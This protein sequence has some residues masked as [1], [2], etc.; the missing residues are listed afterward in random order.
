MKK[1]STRCPEINT[2]HIKRKNISNQRGGR[3]LSN[4]RARRKRRPTRIKNVKNEKTSNQRK[5]IKIINRNLPP[6]NK[7]N[8]FVDPKWWN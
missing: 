7:T 6:K 5:V 4:K 1:K 3:S 8:N 2:A